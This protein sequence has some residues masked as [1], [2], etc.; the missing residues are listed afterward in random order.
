MPTLALSAEQVHCLI[1]SCTVSHLV[2]LC[3][4]HFTL[5]GPLSGSFS[6]A[7]FKF[8]C[9]P[10]NP[11]RL[12]CSKDALLFSFC[13]LSMHLY[14]PF[15]WT[16]CFNVC[17]FK[18]R[19]PKSP[20]CS[21]WSALKGLNRNSQQSFCISSATMLAVL[22]NVYL[23]HHS[24]S[25][26][27][28]AR[29]KE[30]DL[31]KFLCGL[32]VLGADTSLMNNKETEILLSTIRE[33]HFFHFINPKQNMVEHLFEQL[34]WQV[35]SYQGDFKATS[36]TNRHFVPVL[37]TLWSDPL[38]AVTQCIGGWIDCILGMCSERFWEQPTNLK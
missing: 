21:D 24:P 33:L 13:P 10:D 15:V 14:P 8:S 23:W 38:T 19:L 22:V 2:M 35:C 16:L 37:L 5:K 34:H 30:Q 36:P 9:L 7:Y 18:T 28:T 3:A 27:V 29:L 26:V 20:L 6:G 4:S 31:N 11:Y 12:S 17:V 1:F 32:R 25:E